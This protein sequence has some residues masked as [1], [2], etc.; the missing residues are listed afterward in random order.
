MT[1]EDIICKNC[2]SVNDYEIRINLHKTAYC[3]SCGKYIKH[4]ATE[5]PM[6]YYGK[7]SQVPISE[8]TDKSYL[9]WAIS[10]IKNLKT[11]LK[12]AI[13]EQINKLSCN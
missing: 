7:Y 11:K 2:G 5:P 13:Q 10:N 3:C 12:E 6:F 9:T 8:I 4:I 1:I